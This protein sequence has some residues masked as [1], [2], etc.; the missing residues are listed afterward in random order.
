MN[1]MRKGKWQLACFVAGLTSGTA[2]ADALGP[3][4]TQ[5]KDHPSVNLAPLYSDVVPPFAGGPNQVGFLASPM[6]I[7]FDGTVTSRVSRDPATGFLT[8]QYTIGLSDMNEHAIVRGTLNGWEGTNITNVGAAANGS[9]GTFDVPEWTDGDPIFIARSPTT[10]E[11]LEL[12]FR[13]A[14]GNNLIGTVIGPGDVSSEIFVSTNALSF[15]TG[16][17]ALID[18][19]VVGAANVLIPVPEPSSILAM[20]SG[21]LFLGLRRR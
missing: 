15:T 8:F 20:L 1:V 9:S 4:G 18:T 16:N 7:G 17:I 11:G 21:M 12:Q 10:G 5:Y 19:A 14:L 6:T 13:S 3:G 2:M